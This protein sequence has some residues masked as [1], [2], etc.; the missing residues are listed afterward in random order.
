MWC[1]GRMLTGIFNHFERCKQCLLLY[2]GCICRSGRTHRGCEVWT[3]GRLS[4]LHDVKRRAK[5]PSRSCNLVQ[6]TSRTQLP[7]VHRFRGFR[8]VETSCR[9]THLRQHEQWQ[10]WMTSYAKELD[11]F[12]RFQVVGWLDGRAAI[13]ATLQTLAECEPVD[14]CRSFEIQ[15][16][17]WPCRRWRTV[18]VQWR[19]ITCDEMRLV[20]RCWQLARSLLSLHFLP[21]MKTLPAEV[22]ECVGV[23]QHCCTISCDAQ[24]CFARKEC[25]RNRGGSDGPIIA[26]ETSL[27]WFTCDLPWCFFCWWF[28]QLLWLIGVR[29]GLSWWN[30]FEFVHSATQLGMFITIPQTGGHNLMWNLP[31]KC[32]SS[33]LQHLSRVKLCR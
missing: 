26:C 13:F 12:H 27:F 29:F 31:L 15:V 6:P 5:P 8:L 2:W 10:P 24:N 9:L 22:T 21:D 18:R 11:A 14:F 23:H 33:G 30:V 19:G 32:S 28:R 1:W 7:C 16:D 3:A 20:Q 4:Q 25:H 17:V